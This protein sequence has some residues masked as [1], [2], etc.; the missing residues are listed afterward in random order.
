MLTR[1][2]KRRAC[3]H[4]DHT[5]GKTW[6]KSMLIDTGRNKMFWCTTCGKAWTL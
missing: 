1:W 6:I 4:H 2:R 3:F 5:T